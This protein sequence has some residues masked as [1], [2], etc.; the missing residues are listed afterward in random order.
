MLNEELKVTGDVLFVLRNETGKIIE[1][2]EIKNLVVTTGLN[3]IASRMKDATATAMTHMA[4]GTG[5]TAAALGNTTLGTELARVALTSTNVTTNSISYACTFGTGTP[6]GTNAL[7]EAGLFN[8]ASAGTMLC[9][10][11]FAAINKAPGDSL[12]I[13]W[14]ITIS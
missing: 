7:T 11:V 9:R 12:T 14:T 6:A 4:V 13:T 5:T 3:F 8:A 2:K 10:T 1:T